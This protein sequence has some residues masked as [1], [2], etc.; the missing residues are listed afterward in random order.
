MGPNQ[1]REETGD[2]AFCRKE[3]L[4]CDF[5]GAANTKKFL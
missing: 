1:E 3:G 2:D 5:G 4:T